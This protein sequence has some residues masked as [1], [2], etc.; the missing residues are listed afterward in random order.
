MIYLRNVLQ[1]DG[2]RVDLEI[3]SVGEEWIL[4]AESYICLPGLIDPHVHFRTPGLEHKENWETGAIAAARGG[5]TTVFDMPNTVPPTTTRKNLQTKKAYIDSQIRNHPL[6]YHLF[7]G[8]DKNHFEELALLDSSD[9]IGI[10]LFMGSSTGGM[11]LDRAEDR[12]HVFQEAAR[13]KMVVAVHAEEE[14]ILQE[15]RKNFTFSATAHPRLHSQLRCREAAIA[16][17]EVAIDLAAQY[18]TRLYILHVSTKEELNLIRQ[19][20][21]KGLPIFAEA[22]PHHLFLYEEAYET[23]G[24]HVQMNPPL[25]TKEDVEALWEAVLDGTIDTIGSDHAPHTLEEKALGFDK[26]PSGIPGIE[27]TLPLLLNVMHKKSLSLKRIVDLMC[28]NIEKIFNLEPNND[29]VLVDPK[30]EKKVERKNLATKCGWSPYEGMSL[31]GW[32]V[33]TIC[34]GKIYE[35][36]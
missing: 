18:G 17:V 35:C 14:S 31:R 9:A 26:A 8:V 2:S 5:I 11:L 1:I 23:L 22:T 28:R 32:P 19:A 34:K 4:D 15:K 6:R 33:Y 29:L 7:F 3:P 30:K 36:P 10:K 25:R 13:K 24:T 27:T 21:K 12:K 20:K 16:A